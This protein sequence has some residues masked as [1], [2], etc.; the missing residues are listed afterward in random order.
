MEKQEKPSGEDQKNMEY[1]MF[2]KEDGLI[3]F[4]HVKALAIQNEIH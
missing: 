4:M 1:H 3:A 2:E